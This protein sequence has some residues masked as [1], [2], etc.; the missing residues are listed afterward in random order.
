MAVDYAMATNSRQENIMQLNQQLDVQHP[1]L[2]GLVCGSSDPRQNKTCDY[3]LQDAIQVLESVPDFARVQVEVRDRMEEVRK[4]APHEA[5]TPGSRARLEYVLQVF[6]I[7]AEGFLKLVS[8]IDQQNA[9]IVLL[10]CAAE[11]AYQEYTGMPLQHLR[12]V[13]DQAR[14]DSGT[15]YARV[16]RWTLAGYQL[17]ADAGKLRRLPE[18]ETAPTGEEMAPPRTLKA[19]SPPDCGTFRSV[20]SKRNASAAKS[21]RFPHGGLQ[22]KTWDEVDIA[23]LSD[24]RLQI[25][26]GS[27][28]RTANYSEL[29]FDDRRNETPNRAWVML[30]QLATNG[31][32]IESRTAGETWPK[33]EKRLQAIRAFLRVYFNLSEDPIPFVSGHG[34]QVRFKIRCQRSFDS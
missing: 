32:R 13:S 20:S 23:F 5:C 16:G 12:P 2:I 7:R 21:N 15:I 1:P 33:V 6:D 31:G 10:N 3:T 25:R 9:F 18:S 11:I 29:G 14:A 30:L 34:Y 4:N 19:G 22:P 26:V 24:E 17:L 8:T 27:D 28:H